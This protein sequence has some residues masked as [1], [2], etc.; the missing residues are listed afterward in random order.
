MYPSRRVI[1]YLLRDHTG[2]SVVERSGAAVRNEQLLTVEMRKLMAG[3]PADARRQAR[4]QAVALA[5][6][7]TSAART[8]M[9]VVSET[10]SVGAVSHR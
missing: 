7:A 1:E 4:L 9:A 5:A 6:C 2:P 10:A 3:T 8:L